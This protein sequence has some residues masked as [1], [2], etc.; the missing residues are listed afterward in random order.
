[1]KIFLNG[2]KWFFVFVIAFLVTI[3]GYIIGTKIC[4]DEQFPM[5][6]GYGTSTVGSDSMEPELYRGDFIIVQQTDDYQEGDIV[7]FV[8][9]DL[10][11]VHQII[12][13]VE[14]GVITKGT[15]APS[16]DGTIPLSSIYGEVV[17][18]WAG[19]GGFFDF[20]KNKYFFIGLIILLAIIIIISAKKSK[21]EPPQ[22]KEKIEK[23]KVKKAQTLSPK[24]IDK[25]QIKK[26]ISV[27]IET[28]ATMPLKRPNDVKNQSI[29]NTPPKRSAPTVPQSST[30]VAPL[31]KRPPKK[32]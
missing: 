18:V 7:V 3:N 12:S 9:N 17:S 14:D 29:T 1:M 11:I 8:K 28:K 20:M 22:E 19:F 5:L 24:A 27:N 21:D 31:P 25:K 26:E 23:T 32:N 6:L 15:N 10:L 4:T 13:V 2:L 30:T 16:D